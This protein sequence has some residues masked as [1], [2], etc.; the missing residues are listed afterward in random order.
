MR[1]IPPDCCCCII[2]IIIIKLRTREEAIMR[3][4]FPSPWCGTKKIKFR[5]VLSDTNWI[6]LQFKSLGETD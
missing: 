4:H 5:Y 6:L 1:E 2:I 3:K